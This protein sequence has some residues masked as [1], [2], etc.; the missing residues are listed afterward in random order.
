MWRR[1]PGMGAHSSNINEERVNVIADLLSKLGFNGIARFDKFEPEYRVLK[2]LYER[3][4]KPPYLGLIAVCAGVIDYQLKAGGS[5]K[6]WAT[7]LEVARSYHDLNS[8]SQVE[9]LMEEFL[10]KEINSIKRDDK[11]SRI[12][13][14]FESGLASKIVEN[15]DEIKKKPGIIWE[16]LASVLSKTG[17]ESVIRS[18]M[19]EKTIVFAM[20]AFDISHFICFGNYVELPEDIYIPVDFHVK[21]VTI[22]AGLLKEYGSDDEFREAWRMVH[23]KVRGKIRG[24]INLLRL[25]SIVW[26]I[27]KIMYKNAYDRDLS[28]M[29]ITD[30]LSGCIG[31]G[32]ELAEKLAQELT[33][34]I[35]KA[36]E[37]SENNKGRR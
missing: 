5:D 27:G 11:S 34:F 30:Y 8:V 13:K 31:V 32:R 33:R 7:L 20:K 22:S 18:K 16:K 1:K 25:D 10:S 15:Y 3:G 36:K 14:I 19:R 4:V 37:Y 26:Q 29:E 23:E 6:F 17:K 12:K 9:K 28:V 2:I 35:K 24:N 21:Q